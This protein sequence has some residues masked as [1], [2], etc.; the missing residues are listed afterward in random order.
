MPGSS[1]N[2]YR[3]RISKRAVKELKKLPKQV[4]T[5]IAAKIDQLSADPRPDGCKKLEAYPNAYRIRSGDY[6]IV[7]RVE[8][9]ELLIDVIRI[10]DRKEVY[11]KR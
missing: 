6:R 3:I 5:A 4:V 2:S 7:Y 1:T 11:K 9:K 8:D 10:A